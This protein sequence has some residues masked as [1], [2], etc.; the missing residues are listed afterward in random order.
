MKSVKYVAYDDPM[1]SAEEWVSLDKYEAYGNSKR[2]HAVG[3]VAYEDE[4]TI[5]IASTYDPDTGCYR[6]VSWIPTMLVKV[7]RELGEFDI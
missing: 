2:L 7:I 6:H 5:C 1:I 4:S 3:I